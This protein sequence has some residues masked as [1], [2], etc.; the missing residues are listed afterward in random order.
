MIEPITVGYC[1]NEPNAHAITDALGVFS[2]YAREWRLSL[3]RV[4]NVHLAACLPRE[5]AGEIIGAGEDASTGN[6]VTPT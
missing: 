3:E 6:E 5:Q 1:D 4:P 2:N